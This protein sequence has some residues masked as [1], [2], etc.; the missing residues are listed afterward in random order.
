MRPLCILID[1]KTSDSVRNAFS[2]NGYDVPQGQ[3]KWKIRSR[4]NPCI[5]K[6]ML[7]GRSIYA[8][9]NAA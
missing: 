5:T 1:C 2:L 3:E 9:E 8:M 6:A 4:T 7:G